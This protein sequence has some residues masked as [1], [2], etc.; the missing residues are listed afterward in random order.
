LSHGQRPAL[1]I[2]YVV[3]RAHRNIIILNVHAQTG[4]KTDDS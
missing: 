3:L 4:E 2:A 1:M